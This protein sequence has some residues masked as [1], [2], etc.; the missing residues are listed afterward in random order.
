VEDAVIARGRDAGQVAQAEDLWRAQRSAWRPAAKP[1]Q[2]AFGGLVLDCALL[3]ASRGGAQVR[4]SASAEV[5]EIATLRFPGGESWT[6]RRQW[7]RGAQIGFKV[8]GTGSAPTV[9]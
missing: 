7:Q 9:E 1:A 2:I 4:L 6:V 5:P 3:D 8:V